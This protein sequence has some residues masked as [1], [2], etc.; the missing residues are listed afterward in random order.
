MNEFKTTPLKESA[1]LPNQESEE[2]PVELDDQLLLSIYDHAR[3][4][5]EECEKLQSKL[6]V[7]I[8]GCS[9]IFCE[10]FE[11]RDVTSQKFRDG[12]QLVL[13]DEPYPFL[14]TKNDPAAKDKFYAWLKKQK[15]TSLLTL[16]AQTMKSMIKERLL[17]GETIPPGIDVFM[18]TSVT[19]IRAKNEDDAKSETSAA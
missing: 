18:K 7:I 6:N 19:R 3:E 2:T 1:Y 12:S 14:D 9:Q 11:S 8:E 4:T 17:N 15:L 13:K 10:R 16:N 5:Q